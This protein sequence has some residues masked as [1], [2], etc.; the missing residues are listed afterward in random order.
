MMFSFVRH[1]S[2]KTRKLSKIRE[3]LMP[4]RQRF[5]ENKVK[6]RRGIFINVLQTFFKISIMNNR[7]NET[8]Y[9]PGP[10][11]RDMPTCTSRTKTVT[12]LAF[13]TCVCNASYSF[14][15]ANEQ[16]NDTIPKRPNPHP[17]GRHEMF[18]AD[19]RSLISRDLHFHVDTIK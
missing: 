11:T 5:W 12:C 3:S 14:I 19:S 8:G 16:Y 7:R 1:Y 9:F 10:D 2:L 6:C 4:C 17:R 18:P 15:S 13:C